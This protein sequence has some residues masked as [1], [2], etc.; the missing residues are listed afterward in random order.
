[1]RTSRRAGTVAGALALALAGGSGAVAVADPGHGSRGL[2]K[3]CHRTSSLAHPYELLKVR[4]DSVQFTRHLQHRSYTDRHG[5]RDLVDGVDGRID[6]LEDCPEWWD[7]QDRTFKPYKWHR[8]EQHTKHNKQEK[9]KQKQGQDLHIHLYDNKK[10]HK[11]KKRHETYKP[12]ELKPAQKPKT[13]KLA[14]R[15]VRPKG[16]VR[17]S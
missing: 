2:V 1:M 11:S 6:S 16:T 14:P 15:G 9:L 10:N 17:A 3:I 12:R 8:H 13:R 4:R 7:L 5:F